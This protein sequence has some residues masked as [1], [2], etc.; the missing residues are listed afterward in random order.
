MITAITGLAFTSYVLSHTVMLEPVG[1]NSKSPLT[2]AV[3]SVC[4]KGKDDNFNTV[5]NVQAGGFVPVK[6]SGKDNG[7]NN[8]HYGGG[9]AFSLSYDDGKTFNLLATTSQRCPILE[10]QFNVPIPP[11]APSGPALFTWHWIPTESAA[12]EYYMTCSPIMINGGAPRLGNEPKL[13]TPPVPIL[14]LKGTDEWWTKVE[15]GATSPWVNNLKFFP[16]GNQFLIAPTDTGNSKIEAELD[17]LKKKA[18]LL[19][20]LGPLEGNTNTNNAGPGMN[21]MMNGVNYQNYMQPRFG[22]GNV[23]G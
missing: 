11:N 12:P 21:N 20:Q 1:S 15:K 19:R 22:F 6:L 18:N 8:P 4:E 7:G 14:N 23:R 5:T 9:C 16:S 17:E 13:N 2:G 3:K 10:K